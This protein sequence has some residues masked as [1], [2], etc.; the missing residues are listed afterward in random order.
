MISKKALICVKYVKEKLAQ[1]EA[2]AGDPEQWISLDELFMDWDSWD[3][4]GD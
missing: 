3:T 2:I 1:A 4:E